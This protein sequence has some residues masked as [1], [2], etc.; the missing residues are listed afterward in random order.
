MKCDE[1]NRI[2]KFYSPGNCVTLF[3]RK[4]MR[5]LCFLLLWHI[6]QYNKSSSSASFVL[7]AARL[8][9]EWKFPILIK[10]S[11]Q[12]TGE[13]LSVLGRFLNRSLLLSG[14]N[15]ERR[16][17]KSLGNQEIKS[18]FLFHKSLLAFKIE[19]MKIE[20]ENGKRLNGNRN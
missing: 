10:I 5:K 4:E 14:D 9:E 15:S 2:L 3:W 6:E 8:G 11:M 17:N 1:E 19:E 18:T 12:F 7:K 16:A 13:L 20:W